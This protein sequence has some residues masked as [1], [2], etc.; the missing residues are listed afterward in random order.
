MFANAIANCGSSSAAR[1]NSG[2]AG[3]APEVTLT[4]D[5]ALYALSASSDDVVASSSGVEC[6]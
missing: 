3:I 2:S 5:A 6:F 1:L 4:F